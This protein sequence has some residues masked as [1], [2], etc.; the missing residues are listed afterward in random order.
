MYGVSLKSCVGPVELR[1]HER[2]FEKPEDNEGAF[3]KW[4]EEDD[5]W[6]IVSEK[7]EHVALGAGVNVHTCARLGTTGSSTGASSSLSSSS[8]SLSS[9]SLS[10]SSSSLSN[11]AAAG[12]SSDTGAGVGV[13]SDADAD[14]S[15]DELESLS[16]FGDAPLYTLVLV[17]YANYTSSRVRRS[18]RAQR[19]PVVPR[20]EVWDS[21]VL[22]GC[23][24]STFG[25]HEM[26]VSR[27]LSRFAFPEIPRVLATGVWQDPTGRGEQVK[28]FIV[29][30]RV[31]CDTMLTCLY[32]RAVGSVQMGAGQWVLLLSE[33]LH[34]LQRMQDA[35]GFLHGDL[36]A[37]NILL[38]PAFPHDAQGAAPRGDTGSPVC[39][40]GVQPVIIDFDTSSITDESGI[41]YLRA[42]LLFLQ[43]THLWGFI[44][45][46][47][48]H[49]C[50]YDVQYLLLSTMYAVLDACSELEPAGAAFQATIS[51]SGVY[52]MV[53]G[54]TPSVGAVF[55][56]LVNGAASTFTVA[57]VRT[58]SPDAFAVTDPP[59]IATATGSIQFQ[60]STTEALVDDMFVL[61]LKC[62]HALHRCTPASDRWRPSM[63]LQCRLEVLEMVEQG[64]PK[65]AMRETAMRLL[66]SMF[67][68]V[69]QQLRIPADLVSHVPPGNSARHL[70]LQAT[71]D[72]VLAGQGPLSLRGRFAEVDAWISE[73]SW[74]AAPPQPATVARR[75]HADA[76]P[77][78]EPTDLK[79]PP[80]RR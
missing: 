38:R 5:M 50:G 48:E 71:A 56:G 79:P 51:A 39:E 78:D 7:P 1:R 15:D 45:Q 23:A 40:L 41:R 3:V 8:L 34:T 37:R 32:A 43:H 80:L 2:V 17:S 18:F 73:R 24:Y 76:A 57:S 10:L 64:R 11:T 21:V 12:S 36:S 13:V 19:M 31:P 63:L 28:S 52:S 42:D 60:V 6:L 74:P 55:T 77:T 66:T 68:G 69:S 53:S 46:Q 30:E 47:L 61:L 72:E 26:A 4:G 33:I 67:P 22:D 16:E 54:A 49:G 35:C 65:S 20:S 44:P 59:A 70:L 25:M 27:V 62:A 75:S 14:S 29:Y 9:S 58:G